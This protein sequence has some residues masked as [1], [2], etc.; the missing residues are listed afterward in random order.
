MTGVNDA[1]VM[2]AW[3]KATGATGKI[4]FLADGNGEFAKAIGMDFD[5]SGNGLGVRSQALLDAGR[6]RRGEGAEYRGRARQ[7]RYFRRRRAAQAD[8]IHDRIVKFRSFPRKRESRIQEFWVPAFA[9]T[10]GLM[11]YFV[12]IAPTAPARAATRPS[13]ASWSARSFMAW[14]AWPFTQC[15]RTL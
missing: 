9:G 1:F 11:D 3:K 8:L 10:S 13:R 7:V 14:P 2:E 6:R 4:E 12:F 15:Q 5:G